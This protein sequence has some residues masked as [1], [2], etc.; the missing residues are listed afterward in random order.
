VTTVIWRFSDGKPGHDSQSRGLVGALSRRLAIDCH[1]LPAVPLRKAVGWLLT[2][3]YPPGAALPA[4]ALLIGAGH[5]THLP[6]LAARRRYGGRSLVLMK[7]SLP[8]ACFDL[9]LVPRHDMA[10][11]ADKVL[12]TE[13][14]LNT[15]WRS[16]NH[17]PEAGLIIIGGPSR[18]VR[19]DDDSMVRQVE[20]LLRRRPKRRWW[21]TTSP[22]TPLALAE[23]LC[24][25]SPQ[26]QCLPYTQAPP[27]WL[28]SRL[29]EAGEVWVSR[30]S[31]SMVYEALTAGAQ[32]GLLDVPVIGRRRVTAAIDSLV[33]NG[34]VTAPGEDR[35]AAG[36]PQP[37]NE[38][39]RCA[40]WIVREW[41]QDNLP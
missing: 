31:V 33:E 22:R 2:R 1:D 26:T 34:W 3:R 7:P 11:A 15:L 17:D 29:S 28:P 27:D 24:R 39:A 36:P 40:D 18:H 32:V 21:L 10:A 38:A 41:L 23:R 25:N 13:G 37:L 8:C 4:A 35:L 6:M 19:W 16:D 9:C 30:D 20:A 14:V 5:A 12:L